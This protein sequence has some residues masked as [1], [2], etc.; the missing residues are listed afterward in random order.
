MHLSLTLKHFS[1]LNYTLGKTLAVN[2]K[3]QTNYQRY[4]HSAGDKRITF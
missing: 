3:K 4:F 2:E 1:S